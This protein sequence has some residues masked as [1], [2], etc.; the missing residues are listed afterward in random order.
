VYPQQQSPWRPTRRQFLWTG[1]IVAVLAVAVLIGYRYG[2]T[3]WD[4]LKLLVVPAVI[5]GGGIWFNSQ[6]RERELEIAEQRAQDEAL[7]AYL[8]GMAQLLTDKERPLHRAQPGDNLSSVARAR[9]LTMLPRL[10]N[11]RKR[12]VLQFLYE[13]GLI[14]ENR[15][16]LDLRGADLR[17]GYQSETAMMDAIHASERRA[18]LSWADLREAYLE[19]VS[20]KGANLTWA[21]NITNE[22]LEQ[23]AKS[24]QR[25]AEELTH[26]VLHAHVINRISP[27]RRQYAIIMRMGQPQRKSL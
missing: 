6:Q 24:L 7:Q 25:F 19:K 3:L 27:R 21:R 26:T 11:G 9:T 14:D 16:V 12:S 18:D 20:L 1:G 5:A 4:W 23:Q 22:Q 17:L 13:S 15:S 2:I 8:D 10:D